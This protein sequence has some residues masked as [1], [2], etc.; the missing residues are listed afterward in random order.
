MKQTTLQYTCQV[1][2]QQSSNFI[3][4]NTLFFYFSGAHQSF[5][6]DLCIFCVKMRR[7]VKSNGKIQFWFRCFLLF[8]WTSSLVQCSHPQKSDWRWGWCRTSGT[9]MY[10]K[11]RC[12][13]TRVHSHQYFLYSS[14]WAQE[15]STHISTGT[16]I[17][18]LNSIY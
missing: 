13:W 5:H 10:T 14:N 6:V 2:I 3:D 18:C 9:R 8:S 4:Q 1:W 7:Q 15:N 11:K 16:S 17:N 12:S